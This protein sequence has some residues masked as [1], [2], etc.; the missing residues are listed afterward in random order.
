MAIRSLSRSQIRNALQV[1]FAGFLATGLFVLAGPDASRIDAFYV[2]YGVAR[3]LLPTP[4]A[5]L[6]AARARVIGTVFGGLVVVV[7]LQAVSNWLA[8]GVGYALIKLVGRRLGFD[9]GTLTNAVVMAVLLVAVPDYEAMGNAYVLYRT[10]WHLVGLLIGMTIERLFWFTPLLV[11]LQQSESNLIEQLQGLLEREPDGQHLTLIQAY[12]AHCS[13]RSLVLGSQ[14]AWKLTTA[15]SQHRQEWLERAV[16]HGVAR[17]RAPA[18]LEWIDAKGCR[19]ALHELHRCA[20][21]A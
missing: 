11:R 13:L 15:D 21:S 5:S 2:V 17:Q 16:R 19:E 8:V 6:K 3:S 12:T 10:L 1:G 9:Q 20:G 18:Q 7:L 4:E 14:Q